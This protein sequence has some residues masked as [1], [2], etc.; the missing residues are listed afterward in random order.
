MD[1]A[2]RPQNE[3]SQSMDAFR[4]H[5]RKLNSLMP[6]S[7]GTKDNRKR[8]RPRDQAQR[9]QQS[10]CRPVGLSSHLRLNSTGFRPWLL[11]IAAC[12]F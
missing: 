7:K 2:I 4:R 6:S 5:G 12:G 11:T 8:D 3:E 1:N 10:V 9:S